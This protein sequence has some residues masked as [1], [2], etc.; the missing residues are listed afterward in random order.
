MIPALPA[1]GFPSSCP[2]EGLQH[3]HQSLGPCYGRAESGHVAVS[4]KRSVLEAQSAV[5]K[6]ITR[7]RRAHAA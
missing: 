1:R 2:A 3:L 5:G 7:C 4:G 6:A